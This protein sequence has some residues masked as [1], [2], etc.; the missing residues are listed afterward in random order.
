MKQTEGI[1]IRCTEEEKE[2]IN[3]FC[4]DR[5]WK[6]G[7]WMKKLAFDS[8]EAQGRAVEYNMKTKDVKVVKRG[9]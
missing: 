2:R 7:P 4:Q 8:I 9:E 1:F 5:M 6:V 3:K